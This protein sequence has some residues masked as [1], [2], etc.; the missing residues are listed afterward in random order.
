[1][2]LVTRSNELRQG[3]FCM[4]VG[5]GRMKTS[6]S[7]SRPLGAQNTTTEGRVVVV[8]SVLQEET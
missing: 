1:M 3:G 5:D 8:P 4:P 6:G 2:T 7:V